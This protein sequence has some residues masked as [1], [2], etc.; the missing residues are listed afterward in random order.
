MEYRLFTI[1]RY[2]YRDYNNPKSIPLATLVP[3]RDNAMQRGEMDIIKS[4]REG[5]NVFLDKPVI[6]G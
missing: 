6:I 4:E 3:A 2:N 5:R 1:V